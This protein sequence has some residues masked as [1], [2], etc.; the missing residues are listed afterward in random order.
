MWEKPQSPV[1]NRG[2]S[3]RPRGHHARLQPIGTYVEP[4]VQVHGLRIQDGW[5]SLHRQH[6][7]PR[8]ELE[9]GIARGRNRRGRCRA[10]WSGYT[11]RSVGTGTN[12]GTS[13][14]AGTSA[15]TNN[16]ATVAR[17]IYRGTCFTC[18]QRGHKF[19][20]QVISRTTTDQEGYRQG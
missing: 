18:R 11:I 1:L 2:R 14:S 20:D 15:G 10:R 7:R 19:T 4:G 6:V 17:P 5:Q 16:S 3:T 12:T 13:T 8:T 9:L